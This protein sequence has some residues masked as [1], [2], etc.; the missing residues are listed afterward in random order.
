MANLKFDRKLNSTL[1]KDESITVPANEVWKGT[2]ISG[3]DSTIEYEINGISKFG[4][5]EPCN[6]FLGGGASLL[7]L[8]HLLGLHLKSFR[9]FN[10]FY[11]KEVALV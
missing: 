2:I 11:T 9:I 8:L 3:R 10:I 6:I 1:K 5:Q 4:G 7:D